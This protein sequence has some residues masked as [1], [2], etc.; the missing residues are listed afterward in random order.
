MGGRVIGRVGADVKRGTVHSAAV[1]GL[2][3]HPFA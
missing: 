2:V 3:R 1:R